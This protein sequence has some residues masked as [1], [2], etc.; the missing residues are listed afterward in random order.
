M[1]LNQRR[2]LRS[3]KKR[4]MENKIIKSIMKSMQCPKCSSNNFRKFNRINYPFGKKSKGVK[5]SGKQCRDC[6]YIKYNSGNR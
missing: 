2:V 3:Y 1:K 4:T 6:N 5:S